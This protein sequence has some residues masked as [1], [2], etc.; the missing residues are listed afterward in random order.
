MIGRLRPLP[1]ERRILSGSPLRSITPWIVAVMSFTILLVAAS[2][3][4]TARAA[5]ELSGSIGQRFV[6]TVPAGDADAIAGRVGSLPGI[7]SAEAVSEADMRGTLKHWLGPSADS[8]DLPIPAL[9]RFELGQGA[10][11]ERLRPALLRA[12]PGGAVN[13]YQ[14]KV[15]PLLSSLRLVQW[16]ALALVLL[17]GAAASSAVV[18]AARGAIDSHRSTVDV[19]HG[20]GATD[21]QVT[22]IFQHR[23]ALDTL[24]GSL[25]GAAAAGAVILILAGGARWAAD[26]SGLSLGATD[27]L[28]LAGLPLLLTIIATIAARAAILSALR[29]SL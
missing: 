22:R 2:G 8:A 27:L 24:V 29:E 10:S 17:L 6:L 1:A 25:A 11:I 20:I 4:V 9:V 28:M 16:V 23:I 13:S 21:N 3:L 12:A 26:M 18:L 19:L 7:R 5:G 15:A 14:D